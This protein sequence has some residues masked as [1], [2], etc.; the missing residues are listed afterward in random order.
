[1][2]SEMQEVH[3]GRVT[4]IVVLTILTVG[5]LAIP[6][7][8]AAKGTHGRRDT[9]PPIVTISNPTDGAS[10][11]GSVLVA[12]TASDARG[13][14]SISVS[15]D[16]GA[17]LTASGTT[18]WTYALDTTGLSNASHTITSRAT[19]L[20]GNSSTASVSVV[21]ANT[22][23]DATAPTVAITNPQNG[24]TETSGAVA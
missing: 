20:A 4:R 2:R 21:V 1:M 7:A 10:I 8:A 17:Y 3:E 22:A 12:G 6:P 19:D 18:S 14:A 16:S 5:L 9:V 23:A 13:V 11:A 24:A 15:I